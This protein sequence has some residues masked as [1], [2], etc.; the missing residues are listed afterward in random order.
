MLDRLTTLFNRSDPG[1]AD[2]N[3][4]APELAAAAL[5]FEVVW[6]DH[7]IEPSELQEVRTLLTALFALEE[8]RVDDI[9]AQTKQDH[10]D[11]VG[12]F[13]YTRV[14]NEHLSQRQKVDVVTAMWRIAYADSELSALEEHTIRRI[15][16]LLYVS[17]TDFIGAKLT[18]RRNARGG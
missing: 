3:V 14:L 12:V 8:A 15:A 16:E 7:A 17:H 4:I 18:A 13:P 1:V 11:S 5:L 2:D 9:I 10:E 6:A